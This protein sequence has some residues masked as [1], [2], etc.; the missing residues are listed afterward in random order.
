MTS[1]GTMIK[2]LGGMVDTVD[3]TADQNKFVKNM[4]ART[5]DGRNTTGL[6]EGQIEYLT[7]LHDRHFA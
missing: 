1:L 6:S 7:G 5:N 3:L 2:K 4:L